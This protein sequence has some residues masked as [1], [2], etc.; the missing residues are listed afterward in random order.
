MSTTFFQLEK[1][2]RVQSK[3][4]IFDSSNSSEMEQPTWTKQQVKQLLVAV[5]DS[6]VSPIVQQEFNDLIVKLYG[7]DLKEK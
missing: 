5:R 7:I 3:W 1:S 6:F 2:C 4:R